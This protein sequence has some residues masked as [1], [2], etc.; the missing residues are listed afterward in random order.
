MVSDWEWKF[1]INQAS[2]MF[3]ARY[4]GCVK[5]NRWYIARL[6]LWLIFWFGKCI[7]YGGIIH[8]LLVYVSSSFLFEAFRPLWVFF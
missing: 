1:D 6:S 3:F 2:L 4:G 7:Y 8:F 5:L